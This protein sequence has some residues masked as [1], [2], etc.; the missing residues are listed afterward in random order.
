MTRRERVLA[1]LNFQDTDRVPMD[2]GGMDSSGIS[3]FAYP[4][5]VAALGLP[6]RLPRVHDTGQMLAL[7]EVDVLDALDCDVA[8]VRMDFSNVYPQNGLWHPFD[9]NGR[10][11]ALVRYPGDFT[12]RPDG[13]I[14]QG[15]RTMPPA[16]HVFEHEHGGQPVSLAGDIPRPAIGEVVEAMRRNRLRDAQI[17]TIRDHCRRARESSDRA[18][19]FGGPCCPIGI[20]SYTGIA[21]FPLLCLTEPDYVAELHDAVTSEIVGQIAALLDEIHPFIDVYHVTSDDWGTQNS[22]IASP[23]TY[24]ALFQ[25][26]YRRMNDTVHR[27]APGVKTFLHTCGAV[28]DLL[29]DFI[30]S[31]FDVINP[32]QWTAGSHGYRDWKEKTRGRMAL[33]GGGVQ[34][35][36]TLPLGTIQD[37]EREVNEVVSC[38]RQDGGF[39]FAAIHN[40]LAEIPGDKIVAMYRAAAGATTRADLR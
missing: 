26:S 24:R 37:V 23:E 21:M 4:G 22:C 2:L 3:C 33:W 1:A 27:H 25:P 29:E 30:E 12:I 40:L 31:G 39:V 16:A 15:D 11:P 10:L 28:F 35:Q 18:I 32:V 6:P 19:L 36:R 14:E 17:A 38:L 5:L 9:F 7:P 20:G 34:T 13:T 8:S